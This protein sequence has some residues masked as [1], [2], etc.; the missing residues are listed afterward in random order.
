MI[1]AGRTALVTGATGGIGHAIARGLHVGGR[2]VALTGRRADVLERWRPR[3]AREVIAAD[4]ASRTT[5][6]GSPRARAASTS[7]SRTPACPYR[8]C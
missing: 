7:S 1:V 5:S 3:S 2:H 4:L 6:C 8:T